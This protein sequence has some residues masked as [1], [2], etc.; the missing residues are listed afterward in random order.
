MTG[1]FGGR[2]QAAG[3]SAGFAST[4]G[5]AQGISIVTQGTTG[6]DFRRPDCRDERNVTVVVTVERERPADVFTVMRPLDDLSDMRFIV[7]K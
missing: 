2:P 3:A 7:I 4:D 5:G 6:I 1:G